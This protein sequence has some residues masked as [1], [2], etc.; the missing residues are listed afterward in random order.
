MGTRV[1][2]AW[3][4]LTTGCSFA[5]T[6]APPSPVPRAPAVDCETSS[7]PAVLDL[8]MASGFFVLGAAA[9]SGGNG[10]QCRNSGEFCLDLG[11]S[12]VGSM[13][14][15][16]SLSFAALTGVSAA[17]GFTRTRACREA[18]DA[19]R[20]CRDGDEEACAGLVPL[21]TAAAPARE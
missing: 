19:Q 15:A 1:L 8:I 11:M 5:F 16:V 21:T 3:L 10:Q 2:S 20:A 7:V 18:G 14:G 4:S 13:I 6:T 12:E 9:L 17:F